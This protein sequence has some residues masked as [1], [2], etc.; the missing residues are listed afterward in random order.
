MKEL[1][2]GVPAVNPREKRK[3]LS[4]SVSLRQNGVGPEKTVPTPFCRKNTVS[5]RRTGFGKLTCRSLKELLLR[6]LLNRDLHRLLAPVSQRTPD[7]LHGTEAE[8]AQPERARDQQ[9]QPYEK[10][11]LC[12]SI[13]TLIFFISGGVNLGVF[14]GSHCA[15]QGETEQYGP[16]LTIEL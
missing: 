4:P 11:H 13:V 10:D 12:W 1:L 8:M 5:I 2:L 14:F 3:Y 7:P 15:N 9:D 6:L 16:E